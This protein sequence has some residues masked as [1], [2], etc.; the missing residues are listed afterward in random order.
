V[1]ALEY[2][3]PDREALGVLL[4]A[5]AVR[6]GDKPVRLERVRRHAARDPEL[7]A[8]C[9]ALSGGSWTRLGHAIRNR[10]RARVVGGL[11]LERA[12][13]TNRRRTIWRLELVWP[14]EAPAIE[15]GIAR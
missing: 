6:F 5:W 13:R 4:R 11:R 10:L 3:G 2:Q 9:E 15:G 1:A 7:A 14:A 12:R 8:A